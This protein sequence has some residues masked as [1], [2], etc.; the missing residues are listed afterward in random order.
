MVGRNED[1]T[2]R[3]LTPSRSDLHRTVGQVRA[4]TP[5]TRS[6]VGTGRRP[7]G[8]E[9]TSCFGHPGGVTPGGCS[10]ARRAGRR[11]I[12]RHSTQSPVPHTEPGSPSAEALQLPPGWGVDATQAGTRPIVG[13]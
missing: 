6:A 9:Q 4:G 2:H 11:R 13:R 1:V 12:E 10:A 8:P 3:S 5:P 7:L